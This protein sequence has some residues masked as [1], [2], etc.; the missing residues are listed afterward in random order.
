MTVTNIKLK[1]PQEILN[2]IC[3]E[4]NDGTYGIINDIPL[5]KKAG[6]RMINYLPERLPLFDCL[7]LEL[8]ANYDI[9]A[10]VTFDKHFQNKGFKILS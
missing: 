7:Y 10:I 5:L 1:Q 2:K 3:K 6:K 8:T 9:E 4:L